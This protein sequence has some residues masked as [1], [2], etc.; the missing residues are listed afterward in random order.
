M[1]SIHTHVHLHQRH[2]TP[3]L[4][5]DQLTNYMI[6]QPKNKPPQD[7]TRQDKTG[8]AHLDGGEADGP[9]PVAHKDE[10]RPQVAGG[11]VAGADGPV[12]VLVGVD[13]LAP[14]RPTIRWTASGVWGW[15]WV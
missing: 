14:G 12:L 2:L 9:L 5:S 13:L 6:N 4:S 8:R 7:K 10:G 11:G 15:G 1:L 3:P